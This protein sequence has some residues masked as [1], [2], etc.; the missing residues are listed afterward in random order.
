MQFVEDPLYNPEAQMF[1]NEPT[2][3]DYGNKH[4]QCMR[5]A[6]NKFPWDESI[7]ETWFESPVPW[8]QLLQWWS[9]TASA[10][11]DLFFSFRIYCLDAIHCYV[12][13]NSGIQMATVLGPRSNARLKCCN[14]SHSHLMTTRHGKDSGWMIT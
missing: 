5:D 14:K 10:E 11:I 8:S 4:F 9:R 6:L 12:D 13:P 1:A 3:F 2:D 7:S